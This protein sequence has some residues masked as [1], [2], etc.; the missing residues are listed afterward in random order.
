MKIC[1]GQGKFNKSNISPTATTNLPC[2]N[3]LADLNAAD[4]AIVLKWRP[5]H[6]RKLLPTPI[7][8]SPNFPHTGCVDETM[9]FSPPRRFDTSKYCVYPAA[10]IAKLQWGGG[11]VHQSNVAPVGGWMG[12]TKI[13]SI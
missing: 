6:S 7:E 13:I 5:V 11:R 12:T 2:A 1:E 8:I 10:D 4:N 9:I 3:I